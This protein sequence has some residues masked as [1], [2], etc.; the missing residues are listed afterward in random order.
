[1]EFSMISAVLFVKDLQR[2]AAFYAGALGM[3]CRFSDEYHSV[4]NCAGFD[5]IVHQIPRHIADGITIENPPQ[6]RVWGATRLDYPVP[7]IAASRRMAQSLGGGIDDAPPEWA[8]PNTNF[9][10]GHDPEGNQFGVSERAPT[11]A[12]SN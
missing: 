6:R 2:V 4:M 9:F 12:A 8:E 11:N 5:L 10:L 1:M 3:T 7:N